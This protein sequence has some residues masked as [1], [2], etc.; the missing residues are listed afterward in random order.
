MSG[1]IASVVGN[2]TPEADIDK[3]EPQSRKRRRIIA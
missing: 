1:H 2:V 3:M